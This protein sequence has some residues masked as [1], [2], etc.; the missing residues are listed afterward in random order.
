MFRKRKIGEGQRC[1][2]SIMKVPKRSSKISLTNK[3]YNQIS[4]N[5]ILAITIHNS[6]LVDDT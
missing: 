2:K 1:T 5:K 3:N 6:K 4:L